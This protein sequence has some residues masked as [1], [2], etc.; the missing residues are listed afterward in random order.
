MLITINSDNLA[1]LKICRL[2]DCHLNV[3]VLKIKYM[4]DCL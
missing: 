1:T 2:L 3:F 4:P